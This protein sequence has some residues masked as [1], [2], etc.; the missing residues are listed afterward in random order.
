MKI[1]EIIKLQEEH[2]KKQNEL[3]KNKNS[4]IENA[5]LDMI[6]GIKTYVID[7]KVSKVDDKTLYKLISDYEDKFYDFLMTTTK[8]SLNSLKDRISSTNPQPI[9]SVEVMLVSNTIEITPKVILIQ[10]AINKLAKTILYAMKDIS[11][12]KKPDNSNVISFHEKVLKDNEI[13]KMILLLTGSFQ[14]NNVEIEKK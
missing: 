4:E 3:L 14:S 1:N 2:V 8:N 7:P 13:V 12:W 9:F 6:D 11:S 5:I 10:D